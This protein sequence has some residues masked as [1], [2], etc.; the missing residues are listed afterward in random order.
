MDELLIINITVVNSYIVLTMCLRDGRESTRWSCWFTLTIPGPCVPGKIGTRQQ[1]CW[2]ESQG[3]TTVSG[4]DSESPA[5]GL[6]SSGKAKLSKEQV[7]RVAHLPGAPL[8]LLLSF[9]QLF[10]RCW[11]QEGTHLTRTPA[12]SAQNSESS[13]YCLQKPFTDWAVKCP[14]LHFCHLSWIL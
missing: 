14:A 6:E 7:L 5:W 8:S 3:T 10:T 12:E 13:S 4:L 11:H 2:R 1:W 9:S